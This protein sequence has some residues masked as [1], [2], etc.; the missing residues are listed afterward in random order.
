MPLVHRIEPDAAVDDI[1]PLDELF[2]RSLRPAKVMAGFLSSIGAMAV[3]VAALGLFAISAMMV[4]QRRTELAIRIAVGA[5]PVALG[6]RVEAE[7]LLLG[8]I[9]IAGGC[10]LY[11][12][13]ARYFASQGAPLSL[14]WSTAAP[15][16][17]VLLLLM[18][19]AVKRP[20]H[21]LRSIELMA[22]LR[23]E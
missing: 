4:S 14:P 9:G 15:A 5:D 17:G 18:W 20:A 22:E 3:V 8:S 21:S 19:L 13:L 10:I 1:V 12:A 11:R 7:G 6:R 23:Q 2:D 16:A